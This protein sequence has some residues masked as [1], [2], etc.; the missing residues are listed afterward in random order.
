MLRAATE[1]AGGRHVP[2]AV[3]GDQ[4]RDDGTLEHGAGHRQA[5]MPALSSV[6]R[7]PAAASDE[8]YAD[9]CRSRVDRALA[10][11][12][13]ETDIRPAHYRRPVRGD[14][15]PCGRSRQVDAC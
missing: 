8:A 2:F 5:A 14:A 15:R 7:L 1:S 12:G 4:L 9:Y 3:P 10:Q 6:W 13:V 11:H